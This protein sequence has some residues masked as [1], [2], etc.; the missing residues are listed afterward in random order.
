[1]A[2]RFDV[3]ILNSS[4]IVKYLDVENF[5]YALYSETNPEETSLPKI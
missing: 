4:S 5:A 1:M 2:D 3:D